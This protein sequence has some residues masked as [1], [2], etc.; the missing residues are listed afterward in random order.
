MTDAVVQAEVGDGPFTLGFFAMVTGPAAIRF[1]SGRVVLTVGFWGTGLAP[2]WAVGG[3]C[4][5]LEEMK[6]RNPFGLLPG[7]KKNKNKTYIMVYLY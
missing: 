4:V 2:R 1:L 5:L 6:D 3:P 7:L